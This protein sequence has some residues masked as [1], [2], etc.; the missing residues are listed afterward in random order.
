[1]GQAGAVLAG[2]GAIGARRAGAGT[3]A[4]VRAGGTAKAVGACPARA[5]ENLPGAAAA[6][7]LE[8]RRPDH[9]GHRPELDARA[10]NPTHPNSCT[11]RTCAL[12]P[13]YGITLLVTDKFQYH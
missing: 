9:I 1:M 13:A 2:F 6:I 7:A 8:D 11:G 3:A 10:Q 12:A 4:L 5:L